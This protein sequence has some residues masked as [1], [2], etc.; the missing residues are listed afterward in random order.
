L[1]LPVVY[2]D[3][4]LL[5]AFLVAALALGLAGGWLIA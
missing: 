2:I 1:S 3:L 4:G 5:A